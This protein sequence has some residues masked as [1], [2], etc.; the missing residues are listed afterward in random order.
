M[1]R[2][3][4]TPEHWRGLVEGWPASGLTQAQYCERHGISIASLHRWRERL[5]GE[6]RSADA[7]GR[8]RAAAAAVR[9]LPVQLQ[10]EP[11]MAQRCTE[12]RVVFPDGVRVDITPGVDAAT[13]REVMALLRERPAT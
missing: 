1:A 8:Q 9:L 10:G 13:L 6:R 12:L 5:A 7:P 11:A 3:R 4:R 2:H